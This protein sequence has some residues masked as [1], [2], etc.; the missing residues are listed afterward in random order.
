MIREDLGGRGG[1]ASAREVQEYNLIKVLRKNAGVEA[2]L[3]GLTKFMDTPHAET[4]VKSGG[5]R[6]H[7]VLRKDESS[8][9]SENLWLE[10]EDL[11]RM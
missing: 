2:P 11:S 8:S 9:L 6:G 3:P 5:Q 1:G 7:R 4:E 10:R